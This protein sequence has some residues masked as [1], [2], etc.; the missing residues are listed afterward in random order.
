MLS[1]AIRKLSTCAT[2]RFLKRY[3]FKM[4]EVLEVA[5]ALIDFFMRQALYAFSAELFNV[6]RRHH[7][8]KNHRATQSSFVELFLTRKITH[9]PAGKR[10][11]SPGGIEHGLERICGNR[12]I[13][14]PGEHRGAVL[15]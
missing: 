7:R 3:L 10:V 12:K 13:L 15:T 6:E 5:E 1:C 11:A 2:H 4:G 9:Q 14:I 8:A